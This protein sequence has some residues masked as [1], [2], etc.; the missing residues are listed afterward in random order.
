MNMM[1]Y[2]IK[3]FDKIH[4]NEILKLHENAFG[5]EKSGKYWDWRFNNHSLRKPFGKIAITNN[6]IISHYIT[7]P[8]ICKKKHRMINSLMSMWTMTDPKY[9]NMGLMKTLAEKTFECAKQEGYQL[10]IG[11]ANERSIGF[12]IKKFQFIKVKTMTESILNLPNNQKFKNK[13]DVIK[14]KI[15]DSSF[16]RFCNNNDQLK[17]K[18]SIPRT[19]KFLNWRYIQRPKNEYTCYK[20][21]NEKK[22]VGYF[23]LKKYEKKCQIID[24]V[25]DNKIEIYESVLNKTIEFAKKNKLSKISLW[26]NSDESFLKYLQKKEFFKKNM[27]TYFIV[28]KLRN[29]FKNQVDDYDKWYIT[30]GDSD[31]F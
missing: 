20:I 18:Y 9:S 29:F 23:I 7:Q 17:K 31:V 1:N 2:K 26:A 16:T 28:K 19:S 24:F 12:F 13:C 3:K 15:F 22:F 14:I 21:I 25:L 4:K 8:I 27:N 10:V 11:F 30:M 5:F 6:T